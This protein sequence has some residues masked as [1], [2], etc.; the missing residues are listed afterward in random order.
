MTPKPKKHKQRFEHVVFWACSIH[1]ARGKTKQLEKDGYEI[2]SVSPEVKYAKSFE[3]DEASYV[4]FF[5]R[6]V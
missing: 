4:L 2:V 6:P 1:S 5:K 3:T